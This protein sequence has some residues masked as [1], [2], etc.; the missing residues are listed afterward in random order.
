MVI[1]KHQQNYTATYYITIPGI[2]LADAPRSGGRSLNLRNFTCHSEGSE[3]K[4]RDVTEES[5]EI[6]QII[7]L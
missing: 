6:Y 1:S 5:A 4:P 7:N 2:S 3:T